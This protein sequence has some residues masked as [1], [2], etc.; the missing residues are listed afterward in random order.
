MRQKCKISVS[1][2]S[3]Q[4]CVKAVQDCLSEFKSVNAVIISLEQGTAEFEYDDNLD[5]LELI[6]QAIEDEGFAVTL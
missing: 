3:C 5:S 4:H 1:G 2:M 6:G